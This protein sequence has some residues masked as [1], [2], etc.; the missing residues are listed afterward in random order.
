VI[1]ERRIYRTLRIIGFGL[2]GGGLFGAMDWPYALL[3]L[4][5]LEMIVVTLRAYDEDDR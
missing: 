3:T 2:V 5:G 4:I 1:T